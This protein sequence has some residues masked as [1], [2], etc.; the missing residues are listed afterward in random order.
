MKAYRKNF[1]FFFF[2]TQR[3]PSYFKSVRLLH[4]HCIPKHRHLL[5]ISLILLSVHLTF[6]IDR[7]NSAKQQQ[8][9]KFQPFTLIFKLRSVF[10]LIL[11]N[12]IW[13]M[14]LSKLF[15]F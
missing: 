6:N 9:R 15:F 10:P 4:C 8:E 12:D 7:R 11:N 5:C 2:S 13:V 1:F 14:K 3:Q